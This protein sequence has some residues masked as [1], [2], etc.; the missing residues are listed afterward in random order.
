MPRYRI[1]NRIT[2][3]W[4]EE[5]APS[6]QEACKK[7]GWMVGDCWVRQ[8]SPKGLGGWKSPEDAPELG[9]LKRRI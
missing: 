4:W 6:A 1:M 2:R 5:E 9:R 8:Y 7:A 3:E